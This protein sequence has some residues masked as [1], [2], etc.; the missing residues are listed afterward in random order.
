[1]RGDRIASFGIVGAGLIGGSLALAIAA[2]RPEAAIL[3]FDRNPEH[4]RLLASR[5]PTARVVAALE[6]VAEADIVFIAT[7]VGAIGE[8]VQVLSQSLPGE[9]V[10]VDC[11]SAKGA[12]IEAAEAGGARLKR[13]VPGHPLG[14]AIASGP[15]AAAAEIIQGQPFL[16]CPTPT[17]DAGAVALAEAVL[18]SIGAMPQVLSP[19][20]HDALLAATSHL[21][22]LLAFALAA[23]AGDRIGPG[24]PTA[25]SY[26]AITR[27]A[28]ADPEMWADI[29]I[30]NR[31]A[32]EPA[33]AALDA[34]IGALRALAAGGNAAAL[35]ERLAAIGA[36]LARERG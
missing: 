1:M 11:G 7:P 16:L 15:G 32:L 13:F 22:H 3:L 9:S 8:I 29:F 14:G 23:M 17:T 6:A 20:R 4:S 2:R 10:I 28:F 24:E 5:I 30:A 34:E 21:P 27:Y 12:V 25:P 26:R 33:L 36:D 19:E 31:G 35:R 18:R